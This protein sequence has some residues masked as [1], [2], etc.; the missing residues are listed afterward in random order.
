M[1]IPYGKEAATIGQA[2][3][4]G[5]TRRGGPA[6]AGAYNSALHSRPSRPAPPRPC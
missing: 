3:R 2:A 1:V 6:A 5:Q 4:R